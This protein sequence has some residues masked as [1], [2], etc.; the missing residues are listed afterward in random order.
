MGGFCALCGGR[1]RS[2]SRRRRLRPGWPPILLTRGWPRAVKARAERA[3]AS[4]ALSVDVDAA[5]RRVQAATLSSE[6]KTGDTPA[7]L[8]PRLEVARGGLTTAGTARAT[9][10]NPWGLRAVMAIAAT[11]VAFVGIRSWTGSRPN[12]PTAQVLATKVGQRDSL[13]LSDGTRVVLA[14]GSTLTVAAGYDTGDR[15]VT[16]DGA[17]YFD[18]HHDDAHTIHRESRQRGNSRCWYGVY[19]KERMVVGALRWP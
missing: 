4:A 10:A 6:R 9:R 18:V 14:P 17:A 3:T 1:K 16:L 11:V 2:P 5:W 19:G 15:S 7:P 13:V 12:T 8:A